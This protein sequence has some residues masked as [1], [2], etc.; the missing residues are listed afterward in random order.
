MLFIARAYSQPFSIRL[1]LAERAG[2]WLDHRSD[3]DWADA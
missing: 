1:V 2:A 3:R